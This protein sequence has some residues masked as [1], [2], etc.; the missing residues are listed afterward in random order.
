MRVDFPKVLAL[1]T[2]QHSVNKSLAS[3]IMQFND[4]GIFPMSALHKIDD[5]E[6]SP[7]DLAAREILATA[8]ANPAGQGERNERWARELARA[9]ANIVRLDPK[10]PANVRALPPTREQDIAARLRQKRVART[11]RKARDTVARLADM[12]APSRLSAQTVYKTKTA[13]LRPEMVRPPS[14]VAVARETPPQ[15]EAT[16]YYDVC[17]VAIVE[18]IL[19]RFDQERVCWQREIG[20]LRREV[21]GLIRELDVVHRQLRQSP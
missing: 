3:D 19:E 1:F 7:R 20:G 5:D 11:L 10:R 21:D 17:R 6:A 8:R 14:P 2:C 13:A 18:F 15:D 4:G 9:R 16:N 12:Q